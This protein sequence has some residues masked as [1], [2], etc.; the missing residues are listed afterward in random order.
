VSTGGASGFPVWTAEGRRVTFYTSRSGSWNLFTRPADGSAPA[1]PL[2]SAPRPERPLAGTPKV[3]KLLPGSLPVLSG[4]NPQ[5]PM[6]WSASSRTLAFVERKSNAERDIWMLGE[7]GQPVPFLVSPFDESSP[8]FSP[9]GR[10]LA[11]VSDE[12]GRNDVYVQPY[13]GPGGRWLASTDGGDDPVWAA[14][15]HELFYRRGDELLSVSVRTG[16]AFAVGT[17][18]QLFEG[19]YDMSS[20]A[21]NYDIAPDGRNFVFVRSESGVAAPQLYVVLNW[22]ADLGRRASSGR[23]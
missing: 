22:L 16:P 6:S 8:A 18:H 12:S 1:Q 17:P 10:Y 14:D 3:D 19:R 2:I 21:R 7:D 13:P 9:D 4:A 5:Y 15:G 20:T 11:Y 23:D